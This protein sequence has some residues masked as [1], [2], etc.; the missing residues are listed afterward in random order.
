VSAL[1]AD[2]FARRRRPAFDG[3]KIAHAAGGDE[4]RGFLLEN[5]RGALLKMIDSGVL[6]IDVIADFG[7]GHGP[8]HGGSWF[9]NGVAAEVNRDHGRDRFSRVSGHFKR[10]KKAF[11]LRLENCL[12]AYFPLDSSISEMTTVAI[13]FFF[14]WVSLA[15]KAEAR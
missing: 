9:C 10:P 5:F 12:V 6:A 1:L 4:E 14:A 15:V 11:L 3:K 7:F 2:H 13:S 8:T